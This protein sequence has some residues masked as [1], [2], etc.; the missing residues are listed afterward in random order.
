MSAV[1]AGRVSDGGRRNS[2]SLP[3]SGID[4]KNAAS[5]SVFASTLRIQTGRAPRAVTIHPAARIA[6]PAVTKAS[7][8]RTRSLG[9]NL[10]VHPL[11]PDVV[12]NVLAGHRE[13]IDAGRGF[14]GYC[15][16]SLTQSGLG[17]PLQFHG[18]CAI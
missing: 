17:V 4:L 6:K 13:P 1:K 9:N 8:E 12:R 2:T 18:R 10:N 14:V 16:F 7:K 15:Q 3:G 5:A 11:R